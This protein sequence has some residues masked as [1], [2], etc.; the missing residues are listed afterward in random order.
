VWLRVTD[1]GPGIPPEHLPHVFEPF[2]TTKPVGEGSGLGL[3]VVQAIVEEH[4]GRVE[5]AS[6]PGIGTRFT[7][8]LAAAHEGGRLAS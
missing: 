1:D 4:G 6:D 5:V 8:H 2:Y 3:A 7:V